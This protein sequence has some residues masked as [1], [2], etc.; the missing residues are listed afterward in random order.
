MIRFY[1]D[2]DGKPTSERIDS[3]DL[4]TE[5]WGSLRSLINKH[6]ELKIDCEL[7]HAEVAHLLQECRDDQKYAD[8]DNSI[9]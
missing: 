4:Y 2:S 8:I 9:E 1:N 7:T 6:P 5:S 3:C